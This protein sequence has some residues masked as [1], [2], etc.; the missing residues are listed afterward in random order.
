MKKPR[1]GVETASE[2]TC[3]IPFARK[4]TMKKLRYPTASRQ[5]RY[6][7]DEQ[8]PS[9]P[10]FRKPRV[11]K[12]TVVV[13]EA[14]PSCPRCG[15]T[16]QVRTHAQIGPKQLRQPFYYKRWFRCTYDDCITTNIMDPQYIH[17]ND[18]SSAQKLRALMNRRG[19]NNGR[20]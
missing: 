2:A 14:G 20:R 1:S 5:T 8:Q 19:Q 13:S 15:V 17:W 4:S 11:G 6:P 10:K 9:Q 3:P 12:S 7:S 18:N 16:T